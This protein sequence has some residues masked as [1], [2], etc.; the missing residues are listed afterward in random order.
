[1]E[2]NPVST[3]PNSSRKRARYLPNFE[4]SHKR[5]KLSQSGTS[6]GGDR[7][8]KLGCCKNSLSD[9]ET[10]QTRWRRIHPVRRRQTPLAPVANAMPAQHLMPLT[11]AFNDETLVQKWHEAFKMQHEAFIA[12]AARSVASPMDISDPDENSTD[13][14]RDTHDDDLIPL[15]YRSGRGHDFG[16]AGAALGVAVVEIVL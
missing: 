15:R 16:E 8:I 4:K 2:Q 7:V 11:A 1:M 10:T 3:A 6:E 9:S 14:D 13:D 12:A 5:Q